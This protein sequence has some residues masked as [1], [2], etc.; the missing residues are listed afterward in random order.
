LQKQKTHFVILVK[1]MAPLAD[2]TRVT[3]I[4]SITYPDAPAVP[5]SMLGMLAST[6][7]VIRPADDKGVC[8]ACYVV[9]INF[10]GIPQ[11]VVNIAAKQIPL[12][13]ARLRLYLTGR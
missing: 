4:R 7:W 1:R 10:D 5:G 9:S 6:G 11:A 2:G 13:A 3:V 12:V 8:Q